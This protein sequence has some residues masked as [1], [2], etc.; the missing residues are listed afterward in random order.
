MDSLRWERIQALFHEAVDRSAPER[1]AFLES[2]AEGDRQLMAEVQALLEEDARGSSL[3]DRDV[4]Q[5]ASQ[6]LG[7]DAAAPLPSQEFGPYRIRELLGEG[8]MGVVYLARREDL[9]ST[10]AIKVLRDAWM[11]PA[12]RERFATEQRTLA[13]MTHPSIARL[14]DADALADGTPWFAM[15][16]VEGVPLSAYCTEHHSGIEERL[17]LLRDVC[18]AVQ[19]AHSRAVIHRDLKPSNILVRSDGSVKLLDFGI[20]KQLD[21]RDSRMDQTRTGLRVMTPAYAAPEQIRGEQAGVYTDVYALGVILYE[22]LAGALPFDVE[23]RPTGEI[24]RMI[25]E[26]EPE[27]PSVRARRQSEGALQASRA[28]WADLDVLCLTAM[29]KDPQRRYGSVEALIRDLDHY[30]AGEPLEARPDTLRYRVGKFV[31]RNRRAV[32]AAG[33]VVATVA[34]LIIFFTARLAMAR[35]TALAQAARAER[36]QA[37]MLNLFNGGDNEAGPADS[38]RV[39]DL[40]D[41]GVQQARSLDREPAAQADLY[42][43][44]GGIYEKMGKFDQA[45]A[46][47]GSALHERTRMAG[48]GSAEAAES[49]VELGLLRSDQDKLEESERLVRDGLEKAKRLR[50]P[51][52]AA[53]ARAMF[54][55]GQVLERRG[56]YAEAIGILDQAVKLESGPGP[57]TAELAGTLNELANNHFQ[58][59]HYDTAKS[60]HGRALAIHRQLFGDRHPS[61]AF[62]LLDL[63]DIQQELGYYPEAERLARQALAISRPYYGENHPETAHDLTVLGR[64]LIFQKRYDEAVDALQQALEIRE[65]VYGKVHPMVADTVNEL[66][67]VAYMRD[68]LDEAERQFQRMAD[69]YQ[70]VY[71]GHYF[72][73]ATAE[74]NLGAIYMDRKQWPRAEQYFRQALQLYIE[75]QGP[76]DMNVGIAQEKLGH[77]LLRQ[78]RYREAEE[79]M[80]AAYQILNKQASPSV[81]WLQW[82]RKDLAEI[83]D[84]LQEPEKA[85]KFRAEREA[86]AARTAAAGKR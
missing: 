79:H 80:L 71:H 21:P 40:L 23:N 3:L 11:S 8:G 42:Q 52:N 9:G 12:R 30:L 20:A 19:Y 41:R 1:A 65:R 49:E 86:V 10:V 63:A 69:I 45:D 64:A 81:S 17:K 59:G 38:L 22:L 15:E 73:M 50:P 84:A 18:E 35:N 14:Y 58:I 33:A 51:D 82:T 6:M 68:Q 53:V 83:Y 31:R 61:V 78:L 60:L 37:F 16:Y 5:V 32:V 46:L 74:S 54:G 66:G 55:L 85:A 56:K 48:A 44:L 36:I 57:P 75:T 25:L 77:T 34:A 24:E 70:A 29:H 4:S 7:G 28:S 26:Q 27:K 72:G 76:E 2:A 43:T 67:S 13:Q 47:L 39:V 62:D